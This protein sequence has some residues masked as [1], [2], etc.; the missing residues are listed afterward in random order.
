MDG[1]RLPL[2][3]G[4]VTS[5]DE[6]VMGAEV[7]LVGR[8]EELAVLTDALAEGVTGRARV[9]LLRGEAGIGK[10]R[11]L[12][13]ALARH[14]AGAA[15]APVVATGQCVDLGTIGAPFAPVRRLL[16]ELGQAVG[17]TDL[18]RAAGSPAV[19]ATLATLVPEL[20]TDEPVP[21]GSGDY[22]A[23]AVERVIEAL[24][25]DHHLVL[26]IEDLHWADAATLALLRTFASTL[27]GRHLTLIGSYRGEDL[28]RG[29]PL[30]SV[31]VELERNRAVTTV[32]LTRLDADGVADQASRLLG[33]EVG[34]EEAARLVARSEG[35]PF[36]VEEL[37]R[38]G[39]APLPST[40]RDVVLARVDGLDANP[41]AVVDVLAVGGVF[42]AHDVLAAAAQGRPLDLDAGLAS[43]VWAGVIQPEGDGYAFRHALIQEAV[44]DELLSGQRLALHRAYATVLQA[45][46]DG[47]DAGP[48]VEAAAHWVAARDDEAAFRATAV[49]L[50]Q[51][52]RALAVPTEAQCGERLLALWD[53]VAPTT[54]VSAGEFMALAARTVNVIRISGE[55]RR[56]MRLAEEVLAREGLTTVD[57]ARMELELGLAQ[58]GVQGTEAGL[59]HVREAERLVAGLDEPDAMRVR[60][61]ALALLGGNSRD[62]TA[63]PAQAREAARLADLL[64]DDRLRGMAATAQGIIAE[65]AGDFDEVERLTR[66]AVSHEADPAMQMVPRANLIDVLTRAGRFADAVQEGRS[67]YADAVAVG[68]ERGHGVLILSN[69][70]EA[71]IGLGEGE[72]GRRMARRAWMLLPSDVAFRSFCR[73]LE[74]RSLFWDDRPAPTEEAEDPA[75]VDLSD[76]EQEQIGTSRFALEQAVVALLEGPQAQADAGLQRVMT[77][78]AEAMTLPSDQVAGLRVE[79]LPAVLWAAEL[80]RRADQG[81]AARAVLAAVDGDLRVLRRGWKAELARLL[82][83]AVTASSETRTAA[84]RAAADR[85]AQDDVERTTRHVVAFQFAGVQALAGDAAGAAETFAAIARDAPGHGCARLGR[86][87]RRGGAFEA[88][89]RA[90]ADELT[91]REREVLG[92]VAQGLSNPEIARVLFIS[93][94]TASVHVS[95]ILGKVGARS[96]AEAAAWY[97][98]ASR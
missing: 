59:R 31:L 75:D 57:R 15:M 1:C 60:S 4:V 36:F 41:R 8:G 74:R 48:A 65:R 66:K 81:E 50:R 38:L 63:A 51:A 32:E 83:A 67:A 44:Y 9:V 64:D 14:T 93:P 12:T 86:W 7:A 23:E 73:R 40:L 69:L 54:R 34:P 70:A 98:A 94:K 56:A 82:R 37:V 80:A 3:G 42:V 39:D 68:V 90:G 72:E 76:D 35:V 62:T 55:A 5:H 53:K 79:A 85:A 89:G 96:R 17:E 58:V 16:H 77:E 33:R 45:R 97:T 91:A 46:V 21:P 71:L 22:V 47:G 28:G 95:A 27:R 13:E 29:H 92:L 88:R 26:V 61:E 10:T 6:P 18:R 87:A 52:R 30:R 11:L 78:A 2:S 24:S 43:A 84:W 19:L 49:A 20:R 25:Q